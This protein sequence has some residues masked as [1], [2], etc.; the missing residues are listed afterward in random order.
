MSEMQSEEQSGFFSDAVDLDGKKALFSKFLINAMVA[1][2]IHERVVEFFQG[3]FDKIMTWWVTDNPDI[4]DISPAERV[5][6][7]QAEQLNDL[8][9]RQL[10]TKNPI[11]GKQNT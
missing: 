2:Y 5:L 11:S 7:N 3:D 6:L 9:S 4:G 8:V 1:A 10:V